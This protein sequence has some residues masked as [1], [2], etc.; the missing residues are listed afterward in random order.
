M[1][2]AR[3]LIP[4]LAAALLALSVRAGELKPWSGA[5]APPPLVLRD[6][7]GREHKLSDYKGKVV[8]VNFWA[9]WCEPCRQEM[10]AMQRLND[11]LSDQPFVILAVDY[12]EGEARIGQFLKDVPVRFPI[13]LDRGGKAA[14]AW[15]VRV[16]PISFIIDPGQ[17]LRYSVLGDADWSSRGVENTIRKLLPPAR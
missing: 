5:A 8:V 12:G 13:L 15:K 17:T 2:R 3:V 10:P 7:Q 16:L 14:E 4:C 1:I 6:V 9:T 11:R